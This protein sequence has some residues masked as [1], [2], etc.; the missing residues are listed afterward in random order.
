MSKAYRK[1][2]GLYQP[3]H[4]HLLPDLFVFVVVQQ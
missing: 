3:Q 2:P 4:C 1:V